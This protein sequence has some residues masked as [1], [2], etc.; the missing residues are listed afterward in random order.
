[1]CVVYV[2]IHKHMNVDQM[3]VRYMFPVTWVMQV[4][5]MYVC[6]VCVHTKAYE[7]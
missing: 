3:E 5:V 7:Y 2:Y 1:M 6:C 4:C